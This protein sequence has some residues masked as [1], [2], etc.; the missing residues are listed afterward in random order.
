[1][2]MRTT[3]KTA[4][5]WIPAAAARLPDTTAEIEAGKPLWQ[6]LEAAAQAA[7]ANG[8]SWASFWERHRHTVGS[9]EPYDNRAYRRL[10]ARLSHLVTCGDCDGMEPVATWFED[11]PP[12]V[13]PVIGDTHTQARIDWS[14]AGIVPVSIGN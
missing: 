11:D 1:M 7:H 2:S 4:G 10:V 14:T 9:I 5:D 12:V 13:V 8:E 3:K 6:A